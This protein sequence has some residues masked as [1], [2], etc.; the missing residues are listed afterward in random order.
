MFLDSEHY[1]AIGRNKE[2]P[3]T[4]TWTNF[5][6]NRSGERSTYCKLP[7]IGNA[8]NWQSTETARH[9]GIAK[10]HVTFSCSLLLVLEGGVSL[11]VHSRCP[12]TSQTTTIF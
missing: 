1:S 4:I 5:E 6:N 9:D 8:W 11:C 7:C 12:R 3:L 10:G 2:E